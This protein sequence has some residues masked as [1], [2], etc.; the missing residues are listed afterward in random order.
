[1]TSKDISTKIVRDIYKNQAPWQR[2]WVGNIPFPKNVHTKRKYGG[3]DVLLLCL[4]A[5]EHGFTHYYWGDAVDFEV[6]GLPVSGIPTEIPSGY[7]YNYEQ[8]IFQQEKIKVSKKPDYTLAEKVLN[9]VPARVIYNEDRV[10]EYHFPPKDYIT[11][12]PLGSYEMGIGGIN[13]Y[14]EFL[15]HELIHW[16]EPRLAFS[17]S[18]PDG[19]RELRAEIGAAFMMMELKIPHSIAYKNREKYKPLWM[20]YIASDFDF[21]IKIA[22]SATQAVDFLLS[23]TQLNEK[24]HRYA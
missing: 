4:S 3:V 12:P 20:H 23:F 9:A 5:R 11:I 21:I 18:S 15:S 17:R 10:A 2:K 19:V 13:A 16:T 1:M 22:E 7:V 14:Y 8:I 6:Y 24:R